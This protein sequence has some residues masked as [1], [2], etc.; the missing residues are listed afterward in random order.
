MEK[1]NKHFFLVL[2]GAIL[3][4]L[5][6]VLATTLPFYT[7]AAWAGSCSWSA[8]EGSDLT[9]T[10]GNTCTLTGTGT[11][12]SI[13]VDTGGI[14]EIGDGVGTGGDLTVN[15]SGITIE[16][17]LNIDSDSSLNLTSA[18]DFT[19]QNGGTVTNDGTVDI[20]QVLS[21]WDDTSSVINNGTLTSYKLFVGDLTHDGGTYEN[22]GVTTV[23]YSPGIEDESVLVYEG[24]I[25]NNNSDLGVVSFSYDARMYLAGTVG[26][27]SL[28][29]NVG[30]V[31]AGSNA[32]YMLE[33]ST[34]DL[35]GGRFVMNDGACGAAPMGGFIR[36]ESTTGATNT[37]IDIA[38]GAVL[39]ADH[40]EIGFFGASGQIINNGIIDKVDLITGNSTLPNC[41]IALYLVNDSILNN[42]IGASINVRDGSL[43]AE[44]NSVVNN[45]AG[46]DISGGASSEFTT[47]G[48]GVVI[49]QKGNIEVTNLE[50]K[51]TDTTHGVIFNAENGS[52]TTLT[53]FAAG[54][55]SN[56][57]G[58]IANINAGAQL[59]AS[60]SIIAE[61]YGEINANG[62]IDGGVLLIAPGVVDGSALINLNDTG[63]NYNFNVVAM[64]DAQPTY[65]GTL[66]VAEGVVVNINGAYDQ[67]GTWYSGYIGTG[68]SPGGELI[69]NLNGILNIADYPDHPTELAI[70]DTNGVLNI[71]TNGFINYDD[72]DG[73]LKVSAPAPYG[74]IDNSDDLLTEGVDCEGEVLVSGNYEI[75][76]R[77][78][79]VNLLHIQPGGEMH[80]GL[81]SVVTVEGSDTLV[82]GFYEL[83]G[84]LNAGNLTVNSTG[85]ISSGDDPAQDYSNFLINAVDVVVETGGRIASDGVSSRGS[86][87]N[88]PGSYGGEGESRGAASTY[89]QVKMDETFTP[90]YGESGITA[91]VPVPNGG[92]AVRIYATGNITVDG[93]ISASGTNATA[94][95]EHGGAGGTVIIVHE[96]TDPDA[97]FKGTGNIYA[98]GNSS[99]ADAAAL[100]GG[101]G[102]ISIISPLLDDPDRGS[103]DFTGPIEA[104]G[105]ENTAVVPSEW[106][107]SGTIYFGG[108]VNNPNGTLIVNQLN[109]ITTSEVT[110]IPNAGDIVFDRIEVLGGG[111]ITWEADPGTPP[112]VCYETNGTITFNVLNCADYQFGD[113]PDT[114]Y[115]AANSAQTVNPESE[116]GYQV[117]DGVENANLVIAAEN[118]V[119]SVVY[120]NPVDF[121]AIE[122]L[123]VQ[124][125]ND[126]DFSSPIWDYEKINLTKA[127]GT[128]VLP[129]NRTEDIRYNENGSALSALIPGT[130]YYIRVRFITNPPGLWTHG[131]YNDQYKF[132]TNPPAPQPPSGGGGGGAGSYKPGYF[133]S[134]GVT[135]EPEAPQEPTEEPVVPQEPAEEPAEEPVAE[136]PA[137]EEPVTV[138]VR[139][140]VTL[141]PTEQP[142]ERIKVPVKRFA[143]PEEEQTDYPEGSVEGCTRADL[144]D[145]ILNEF[146]LYELLKSKNEKCLANLEYCLLPLI[147]HSNYNITEQSYYPD[148]FSTEDLV[149][150]SNPQP[151]MNPVDEGVLVSDSNPLPIRLADAINFGTRLGMVQGY[152]EEPESP[153][154]PFENMNR[155]EI[156]KLLNW[157]MGQKWEYYEEYVT[158]LGGEQNLINPTSK[159]IDIKE[160]WHIRYHDFACNLGLIECGAESFFGPLETCSADWLDDM[161]YK[162]RQYYEEKNISEQFVKDTDNDSIIDEDENNIFSTNPEEEDTDK[163]NLNDGSEINDYKTNPLLTD[164]DSDN[165]DDGEEILVYKTNPLNPD[166]D[167]DGIPDGIELSYGTDPNN[168]ES[169]PADLNENGIPDDWE[170]KY[171]IK[172]VD[173]TVDTDKDGLSDLLEFRYKTNPLNPDT[174]EDGLTDA[175]EV[176]LYGTDPLKPTD[177]SELGV[178]IINIKDGGILTDKYPTIRGFGPKPDMEILIILKN[179]FGN[180]LLLGKTKT[181]ENNLFIFKSEIEL[182]NGQF[183]LMA[184]G[185]DTANSTVIN[186]PL[187]FITLNSEFDI[188]VPKPEKLNQTLITD[189][190]LLQDLS[191]EVDDKK[192]VLYGRTGFENRVVATWQSVLGVSSIVA[193]IAGGEFSIPSPEELPLGKHKVT[194]YSI[195]ED[196]RAISKDVV[197][198]F[199]VVE[200][201][202]VIS[203]EA[204]MPQPEEGFPIWLWILLGA[205]IISVAGFGYSGIKKKK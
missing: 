196:T 105:G 134:P 129:N 154:R 34:L 191:V 65:S 184:K 47:E 33:Y 70:N 146:N 159:A 182:Q 7:F 143:A 9:V 117:A 91:G 107:A 30:V 36:M 122:K 55:Q 31:D 118:P 5:A 138:P 126:A 73:I 202:I 62:Q 109:G 6:L 59:T 187:L 58:G 53:N 81:D 192:P 162:Y 43:R 63:D 113:K 89:G 200:P 85:H 156:L 168:S 167:G 90:L 69:F 28:F 25:K 14:L 104:G 41:E 94:P 164:S 185:L 26:D 97:F 18:S 139:P 115:M 83:D 194:V 48:L 174:D 103:Y 120:R 29:Q 80:S 24:T 64:N 82:D 51:S 12:L 147:I 116:P 61:G 10:A 17:D 98:N 100:S 127:D 125:D 195:Q 76:N 38:A 42:S 169:K 106:G 197:V 171:N 160:W 66:N 121:S 189:E 173:G 111:K 161:I 190:I 203:H 2:N 180:E 163:D 37:T 175:E 153:F 204:A 88:G 78:D 46:A 72:A 40:I 186:S 101:G 130:T 178:Q 39:S 151:P 205:I 96:P 181:D 87:V 166:T 56:S 112:V 133:P 13:T 135:E 108:D 21:V 132:T 1:I 71:G 50:I 84:T 177:L 57:R 193:D 144:V 172:P 35:N 145:R 165:I 15:T 137:A 93:E 74:L 136:E 149:G 131:D 3:G 45:E 140:Q 44:G 170:F 158:K 152:Y 27:P 68:A 8:G 77:L 141:P 148:V 198:N 150:D 124:I 75:N 79:A 11:A 4:T 183:Y 54:N 188:V 52:T 142:E 157:V 67:G 110:R 19:V 60:N 155:I 102:R 95:G 20:S 119:F 179:E 86:H 23:T 199:D 123:Q 16:G 32:L 49:T 201:Q 92:G 176:L 114:L 99:N 22:N 128:D